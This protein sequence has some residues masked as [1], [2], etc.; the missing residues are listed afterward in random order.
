MK[1]IKRR[2][3]KTVGAIAAAHALHASALVTTTTNVYA[4][5][6]ESLNVTPRGSLH[7]IIALGKVEKL[8]KR[9]VKLSTGSLLCCGC[10]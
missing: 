7:D 8:S 2:G 6:T 1:L 3:T 10:M 9:L 4:A 5:S